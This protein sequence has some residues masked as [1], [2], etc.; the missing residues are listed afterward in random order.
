MS[1][2]GAVRV[3]RVEG[4]VDF[5]PARLAAFLSRQLGVSGEIDI[6]RVGGGQS[7]PTYF[8]SATGRDLVLRKRPNGATLASAH[9]VDREF[10]VLQALADTPAPTPR[11]VLFH[12]EDDVVG[13]PFY[14]MERLDGR[15]FHDSALPGVSPDERRAMYLSAA[16]ALAA[17]HAVDPASVGLAD[18][19][20]AGN[21]FAR[22]LRR[23]GRQWAESPTRDIPELDAVIAWLEE[24]LPPDDGALSVAHGDYRIGNLIFHPT[25][26]RV[27]GILDWELATVGDPLADL[28]FCCMTWLIGPEEYAGIR[29]LDL[30]ALGIPTMEDFVARYEG[31][32]HPSGRLQPFHLAFALFRFAVIFVGIADRARAGTAADADAAATGRLA[33]NFARRALAVAQG[34]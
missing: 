7:N 20:R 25:E 2:P 19:G 4:P 16:D 15:V 22:Q 9:A 34:A 6:A 12:A 1:G 33:V 17:L 10:R 5:D 8:V 27:I 13:T 30:P 29:G 32:P 24:R 11:P 26:P 28:G 14:L 31:R 23:W 3:G 18:F 21:Y